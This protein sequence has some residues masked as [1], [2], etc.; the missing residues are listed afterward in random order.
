MTNGNGVAYFTG[1]AT[2]TDIAK[3]P[4]TS[5]LW[6]SDGTASG[7]VKLFSGPASDLI[8]A[9]NTLYFAGGDADSGVELWRSD[10]TAGGTARVADVI[11]GAASS[12]PRMLGVIGGSL[13]F[14]ARGATGGY[15]LWKTDGTAAGT[16]RL[17]TE[18][19]V[20]DQVPASNYK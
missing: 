10:G 6:R 1:Q 20:F 14:G 7:T 18:D 12:N 2:W 13:L 5:D 8:W 17:G 4:T 16:V 11:P 3:P 19:V 15:E 9:G